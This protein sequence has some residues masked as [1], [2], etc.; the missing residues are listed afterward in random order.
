MKCWALPTPTS[1]ALLLLIA[2]PS[3]GASVF[4]ANPFTWDTVQGKLYSFCY[5]ASGEALDATELAALSKGKMMIHGM[6]EGSNI[7]PHYQNSEAKVGLAAAQLRAVA[8]KQLQLYTVQIDLPRWIYTSGQWFNNHSECLLQRNGS[9]VRVLNGHPDPNLPKGECA[10]CCFGTGQNDTYTGYCP[11][12]GFDTQCGQD[13]WVRLIVEA[14]Q[15][16]NLDGVFIDG[17]QG[18]DPFAQNCRVLQGSSPT[19]TAA[20][21][22]GL[23]S[24]L[25]ALAAAFAK[26]GGKTI[27]CNRTGGTYFCDGEDKCFCSASN[28]ERFGGGPPGA[29]QLMDYTKA[30]PDGGVIVHVPHINAGVGEF[31][32]AFAAFLLGAGDGHGFGLGFQYECARGGWLEVD[33][34]P[35]SQKLGP[36]TGLAKITAAAWDPSGGNCTYLT[37]ARPRP[38]ALRWNSCMLSRNFQSGTTV[39]VGQFLRPDVWHR[40]TNGGLCIWWSDGTVIGNVSHCPPKDSL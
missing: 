36:P 20:Y 4:S 24:A 34:Y 39:F 28:S 21:M 11:A 29:V 38:P 30:N 1:V 25:F 23:K 10:E 32:R 13:N 27:I 16:N 9:V 6:E 37:A 35:L 18:C 15:D 31:E 40:P 26:L 8:P 5:A 14:V 12:F 33:K 3:E 22:A 2:V 7:A 17:F 19:Q